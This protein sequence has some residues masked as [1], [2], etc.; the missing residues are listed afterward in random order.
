M[1]QIYA[2]EIRIDNLKRKRKCGNRNIEGSI[3]REVTKW[4]LS[5]TLLVFS[6]LLSVLLLYV[7]LFVNTFKEYE[8]N[9]YFRFSRG[10]ML[11]LEKQIFPR[12]LSFVLLS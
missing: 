6:L 10:M 7:I 5:L 12:S 9:H 2:Y 3:T 8:R 1:Q 4:P 11:R